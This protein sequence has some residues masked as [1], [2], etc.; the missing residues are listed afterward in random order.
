M[1]VTNKVS[2]EQSTAQRV[3]RSMFSMLIGRPI[4][5]I[6]GLLVLVLLSRLLTKEEYGAYFALWALV[7]I[8]I[9]LSDPGVL[10]LI[11]RFVS[12]SSNDQGQ[13]M[14]KGPAPRLLISRILGLGLG[15]GLLFLMPA[16]W[17]DF[18]KL[19]SAPQIL[20]AAAIILFFE[21]LARAIE[22]IF[23]SM[24]CQG[25]SQITTVSRTIMRLLGIFVC[26]AN[27]GGLTLDL[28]IWV[29]IAA[30]SVGVLLGL[31]LLLNIYFKR[32]KYQGQY[33]QSTQVP[34]KT[35]LYYA[36]PAYLSQT[37]GILCNV[38]VLKLT[39]SGSNGV[40]ELAIFG[41]VFSIASVIQRYLPANLLAGIF[42]PLFIAAA[43][44][45]NADRVLVELLI[46]CIKINWL[47]VVPMVVFSFILGDDL[48]AYISGGKY[49]QAGMIFTIATI[50]LMGFSA[51]LILSHL[52]LARQ[53]PWPLLGAN[54]VAT[55][56][57][58]V[59]I[60]LSK[61][62]GALGTALAFC[63]NEVIWCAASFYFLF[64]SAPFIPFA[65]LN[66]IC[67]LIGVGAIALVVAYILKTKIG[68]HPVT[69][70]A[71]LAIPL[72]IGVCRCGVFSELEGR[73]LSSV[74]PKGKLITKVIKLRSRGALDE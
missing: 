13:V 16:H 4:S 8:S 30:T 51:H 15:A 11:Y 61:W 40:G 58:F 63:I 18:F 50:G 32:H 23:D 42:R 64:R 45:P 71:A 2:N 38:D 29:D 72:A 14:P 19:A 12:A 27:T 7:E 25:A 55:V 37:L 3:K 60:A 44:K 5:A 49:A 6:G 43:Q 73:W 65:D 26:Y 20:Q 59:G 31:C 67:R 52:C 66:G 41:F 46:A 68:I 34:L 24:L 54:L 69:V 48:L 53:T 21:G 39:L 56:G 35:L 10:H 9:L 57:I 17:L 36:W 28:L 33:D 74:M 1:E 22:A 47:F 70:S 62:F